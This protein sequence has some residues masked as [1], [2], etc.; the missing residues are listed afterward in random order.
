MRKVSVEVKLARLLD[1]AELLSRRS[2]VDNGLAVAGESA[3]NSAGCILD[4]DFMNAL[5]NGE[6]LRISAGGELQACVP[7]AEDE[8][9]QMVLLL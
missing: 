2:N 7:G 1:V 5:A 3:T 6:R 9:L 8:C 4:D